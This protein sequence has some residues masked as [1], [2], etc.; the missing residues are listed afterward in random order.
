VSPA[1]RAAAPAA[2]APA[3]AAVTPL[4]SAS[5]AAAEAAAPASVQGLT[6]VLFSA[7]PEPFLSPKLHGTTQRI[8]QKCSQ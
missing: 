5:T 3:P 6:L 1:P 2:P 7:Q 4:T 8:P